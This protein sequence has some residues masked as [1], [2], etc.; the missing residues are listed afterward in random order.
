[1]PTDKQRRAAERRRLQRQARRRRE[2]AARRKRATLITSIV[3]ALVVVAVV[4]FVVVDTS[5]DSSTPAAKGS[6][7]ATATPTASATASASA[8]ATSAAAAYPCTWTKSGTAARKVDVPPTTTPTRS[9]TLAMTVKTTRGTMTFTLNRAEAPCAVESFLSLATQKY[10]DKTPCPRVT[11]SGSLYVLQCGD[12][13]GTG[14]GGPGYTF[15]DELTGKEKYTAGVLAMANGGANTNGSQFFIVY[16]DSTLSPNYTIF[17]KVTK[18][19]S[20]VDKVA[21]GGNDGSNQAGGG[22]PKLSISL[23]TVREQA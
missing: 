20:V 4:V 3:G 18:G 12:P 6:T 22:H 15:N 23:T 8:S 1:M 14:S 16:K 9:G 19:L 5:G 2:R 11:D 7:S 10:F 17:G 21:K 13:T